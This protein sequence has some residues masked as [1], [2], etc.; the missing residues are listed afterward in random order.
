M[1]AAAYLT[2]RKRR[3]CCRPIAQH[4]QARRSRTYPPQSRVAT[5]EEQEKLRAHPV[6]GARI[7]AT[8]P[9]PWPV[10]PAIRHQAEHWDGSGYPDGLKGEEIPA[11]ARILAVATAYSA[12]L[13][14]RPFRSA[15]TRDAALAEIEQRSG[16]QFDPAVVQALRKVLM[17]F[18]DEGNEH[19]DHQAFISPGKG[20]PSVHS[21][22]EDARAALEDIAAAQRETLALYKLSQAVAGSLHLEE[23]C[24]TVIESAMSIVP[25]AAC[26]LFLPE[27][28]QEYLR[29]VRPSV[30]MIATFWGVCGRV[31]TYLTGRAYPEGKS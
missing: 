20:W 31:G 10:V 13:R 3:S 12:L 28:D 8:I 22:S 30:S 18:A 26:V 24:N 23:V 25:C 29:A 21:S 11:T 9:F 2:L 16:A 5:L 4:R 6:L 27:D 14:P 17:D 7:L 1:H 19:D 15:F